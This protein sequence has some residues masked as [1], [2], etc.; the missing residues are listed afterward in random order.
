MMCLNLAYQRSIYV[1]IVVWLNYRIAE[2]DVLSDAHFT[3]VIC[4]NIY[5]IWM[6]DKVVNWKPIHRK[7]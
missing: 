2:F 1:L 4:R 3:F 5:N 7:S 6:R